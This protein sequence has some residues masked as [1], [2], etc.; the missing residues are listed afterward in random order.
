MAT[1]RTLASVGSVCRRVTELSDAARQVRLVP[2]RRCRN[3]CLGWF[4]V[5]RAVWCWSL[6]HLTPRFTGG[7]PKQ[8]PLNQYV[9]LIEFT[10]DSPRG[11]E[12]IVN[13]NPG[14]CCFYFSMILPR[15]CLANLC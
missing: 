12:T 15:H 4:R 2:G 8:E 11:Q 5:W 6:Y 13:M 1:L 3:R 7:P 10:F 14:H 9:P